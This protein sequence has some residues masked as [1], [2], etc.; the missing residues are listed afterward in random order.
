MKKS[1][2]VNKKRTRGAFFGSLTKY[3]TRKKTNQQLVIVGI[4]IFFVV[5]A[6]VLLYRLY[7]LQVVQGAEYRERV[8][9]L[10][11][12]VV[13]DTN[14]ARGDIY[15]T[16]KNGDRLL[17]ATNSE[18]YSLIINNR[19]LSDSD[20]ARKKLENI[21][22]LDIKKWNSIVSK[23]NDPYE[24]LV[25]RLKPTEVAYIQALDLRGIELHVNKERFYPAGDLGSNIIGFISYHE[26]DLRGSYGLEKYYDKILRRDGKVN[27]QSLFFSLFGDRSVSDDV[28]ETSIE[29]HIAKEGSLVSHIEPN[30]QRFLENELDTISLTYKSEYSAGIVL[31][32]DSGRILAM[33]VSDNFNL[34]ED[35]QHYRNYPIEDR[36]ELGSIIKPLTVAI[37]LDSNTIDTGFT[38][39]D[40]GSMTIGKYTIYNFDR[41]G[42]GTFTTLQTILTNSLNTGVATVALKIGRE[43]FAGYMTQLGFDTETGVDLP[44]ESYGLMN[45][46]V[47]GGPV[48]LATASF[49]QGVAPTALEMARAFGALADGGVI[50]TPYVV[51]TI[52]YGDLIPSK[53]V[54]VGSGE[55]IFQEQTVQEV[56]DL[57]VNI[58]D[59]SA[60]FEPYSLPQHSI[61]IKTGT[62]QIAKPAGGYYADQF[63]HS[64]VGFFPAYAAP[65]EQQFL[66]LIYTLRPQGARYSSTTLKD[67][68]FNTA[69]YLINYYGLKPDRNVS[70]LDNVE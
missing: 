64:F 51:D 2:R 34:N 42:R 49:G 22:D 3:F 20:D 66:V 30:V 62:A 27:R 28:D 67:A 6:G 65:E 47:T 59:E 17:V 69:G 38:Y 52:E 43:V 23:K 25:K 24:I 53:N 9:G 13:S 19:N 63:L 48:E 45:N 29:K 15:F 54:P 35:T 12:N 46:L 39:N 68:F 7:F 4:Y 58:V 41:M 50:H 16:Y 11:N 10:Y 40:L 37:G 70:T 57:L 8:S 36:R 60:T 44:F 55:Q 31:D 26:N 1:R 14:F 5:I 56:R 32:P 61:A 18:Y 33:G 21:I